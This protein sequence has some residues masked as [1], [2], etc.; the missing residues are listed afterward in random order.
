[1][2]RFY[3]HVDTSG[4][5]HLWTGTT[6]GSKHP[7]GGFQA[8]TRREDNKVY[9]HRWIYEQLVGPIPD[10]Y[11]IDHVWERGCRD[12]LCVRIEHLEPVT[13]DENKRR[14]RRKVCRKGQHE[15]TEEN[16]IWDHLGR[17][18]GC[19]KCPNGEA[20]QRH[21]DKKRRQSVAV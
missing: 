11:E 10:G 13:S 15:Q 20:L 9:A 6:L 12:R 2:E 8:S 19:L 14:A 5:C 3:R 7:Y 21:F 1:M 18:R 4:E 17:R 16:T